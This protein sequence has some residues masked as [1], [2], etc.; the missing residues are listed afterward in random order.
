MGP[1]ALSQN[2]GPLLGA[3]ITL[4]PAQAFSLMSE[5]LGE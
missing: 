1:E 4:A 5:V 2:E 3:G